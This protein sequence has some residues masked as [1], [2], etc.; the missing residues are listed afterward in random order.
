MLALSAKHISCL[1][2][3]TKVDL[4]LSA[5]GHAFH[6]SGTFA[7]AAIPHMLMLMLPKCR[8][9]TQLTQSPAETDDTV[10]YCNAVVRYGPEPNT[11]FFFDKGSQTLDDA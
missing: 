2:W 9:L 7:N 8:V 6:V 4:L 5:L 11:F 1:G 10:Q 3:V